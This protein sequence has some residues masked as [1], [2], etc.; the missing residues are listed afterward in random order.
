V[1]LLEGRR[2]H[3]GELGVVLS[4]GYLEFVDFLQRLVKQ[5]QTDSAQSSTFGLAAI[6]SALIGAAEGMMRDR[7]IAVRSGRK[8]AFSLEDVQLVFRHLLRALLSQ[9][10]AAT[11][12]KHKSTR[13]FRRRSAYLK[14]TPRRNR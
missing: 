6:S 10:A 3:S 9:P 8:P 5:A 4:P 1:L 12:S 13:S 14:A 2:I 7:L 11:R